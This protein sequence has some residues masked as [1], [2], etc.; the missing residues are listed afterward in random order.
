M[1][2]GA[3]VVGGLGI[4][5]AFGEPF[6]SRLQV[7]GS[8]FSSS[9]FAPTRARAHTHTHARTTHALALSVSLSLALA[10]ALT[11]TRTLMAGCA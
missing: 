7:F 3:T 1:A 10:L 9:F 8:F 6:V 5:G 4:V 2:A 11:R